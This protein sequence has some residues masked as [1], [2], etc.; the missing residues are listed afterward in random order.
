LGFIVG[1]IGISPASAQTRF[2]KMPQPVAAPVA[3]HPQQPDQTVEPARSPVRPADGKRWENAHR[4]EVDLGIGKL[5]G[6]Q[7]LSGTPIAAFPVADP[8]LTAN[9]FPTRYVS[10]WMFGDGALLINQQATGFTFVPVLDRMTTLDPVLTSV[11]LQRTEQQ[12]YGAHVSFRISSL[13]SAEAAFTATPGTIGFTPQAMSGFEATR[14]SFVR[15]WEGMI[16]TGNGMFTNSTVSATSNIG[17]RTNSWRTAATAGIEVRLARNTRVVPYV[18]AAGGL[19]RWTGTLPETTLTGQYSFMLL[20]TAPLSERDI[21]HVHYQMKEMTPIVVL[22]GG[23]KIFAT[24]RHGIR[25]DVRV[26]ISDNSLVTLVD[27]QPGA[28]P[29][30][31]AF[32]IASFSYPAVIFSNTPGVRGNLSGPP[33]SSLATFSGTGR[34]VQT[35]IAVRYFVRF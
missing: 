15:V 20:G 28:V 4:W 30:D 35:S 11:S 18:T 6:S 9:G 12:S 22:G 23:V 32:A 16:A 21:V 25:A 17:D 1:A 5:S 10:S 33:V 13:V 19:M 2:T 31:P 3:T 29:G 27:A 34:E 8:F 26:R 14:A 7:P 24:A